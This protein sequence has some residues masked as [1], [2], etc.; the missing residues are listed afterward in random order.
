[1]NTKTLLAA[2]LVALGAT[3]AQAQYTTGSLVIG[4]QDSVDSGISNDV[5]IVLPASDLT[6]VLTTGGTIDFGNVSS[7]LSAA[8]LPLS[9]NTTWS[10]ASQLGGSNAGP[11]TTIGS[12]SYLPAAFFVTQSGSATPPSVTFTTAQIPNGAIQTVGLD[13][14]SNS[15]SFADGTAYV[16]PLT[17]SAAYANEAPYGLTT[18]FA[19]IGSSVGSTANFFAYNA[20]TPG[21]T[22]K[23]GTV[24]GPLSPT[25]VSGQFE[26][27]STGELEFVAIP[28]PSTYAAILGA[29]TVAIVVLRR[30]VSGSALV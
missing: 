27:T 1:M 4:F 19:S 17:D 2:A 23:H 3:A 13:T 8:G 11:T 5:Q 20:T 21:T 9:A 7:L 6:N 29:L 30:R 10:V 28:E 14:S 25:L 26:V 15:S 12:T 22:G 18:G 24:E 16:V